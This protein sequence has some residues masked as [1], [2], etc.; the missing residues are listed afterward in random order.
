MSDGRDEIDHTKA[1]L[2]VFS[3]QS[4][5]FIGIDGYKILEVR[6][7]LVLLGRQ[8]SCLF[9]VYENASTVRTIAG[10]PFDFH[11]IAQTVVP[12]DDVWN[13][14]VVTLRQIVLSGLPDVSPRSFG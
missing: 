5:C 12:S 11:P 3:G 10:E 13:D 14:H 7:N 6:Q 8:A 2:R 9:Y 4:E 1:D